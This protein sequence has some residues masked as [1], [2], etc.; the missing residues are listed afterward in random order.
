MSM[1]PT[2]DEFVPSRGR[3][4]GSSKKLQDKVKRQADLELKWSQASRI[5]DERKNGRSASGT[6]QSVAVVCF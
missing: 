5:I 1:T 2:I 6:V 4:G 3:A